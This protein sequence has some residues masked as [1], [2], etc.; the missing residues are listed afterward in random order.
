MRKK[1][2]EMPWW[3]IDLVDGT[4]HGF[5]PKEKM[6]ACLYGVFNPQII[7]IECLETAELLWERN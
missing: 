3:V 5:Q 1:P 4:S 6:P 2:I 7:R